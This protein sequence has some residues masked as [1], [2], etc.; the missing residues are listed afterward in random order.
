[1]L[2]N[3]Y[4]FIFVF[5]PLSLAGWYFFNRI[6]CYRLAQGYLIGM[7]LW[8]YAYFDVRYLL[9]LAVS[10]IGGY[11]LCVLCRRLRD[12]GAARSCG[13]LL[14][15]AGC[16]FHLGML[17][18]FKYTGF[19]LE[20]IFSLTGRAFTPLHILLPVGISFYTFQQLAYFLDCVRGETS[21]C[22]F[23]DYVS[24]IVYFPQI[25]QGP[26]LLHGE[27]IGQ[28][29]EEERRRFDAERFAK[30]MA[31]FV[32]GLSKKALLADTLGKAVN[33]GYDNVALLDSPSALFL[34]AGYMIELYFDFSGYCDMAVGLGKMFGIEIAENFD[35]P[36]KS[37]SVKE[38][39][40]RW[41]ITLGRFFT[42]YVY[43]PL[44]GSRKGKLR[45][46]CNTMIVFLF[47][48]FWHGAGWNFVFWGFLHGIGVAASALGGKKI[49][50]ACAAGSECRVSAPALGRKKTDAGASGAAA[51][52]SDRSGGLRGLRRPLQQI[53][54]FAYVTLTFVFF[55]ASTLAQGFAVIGKIFRFRWNGFLFR[56]AEALD[57]TELYAVTK[58]LDMG[59]PAL[60]PWVNLLVFLLFFLLCAFLLVGKKASAFVEEKPFSFSRT[61]LLSV[62]FVWSVLSLS[63]VSTFLYFTF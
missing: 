50:T 53:F 10:C 39:W 58:A 37:A 40:R 15:A 20:N 24:F 56:M 61:V 43:I 47:S 2:F 31:R 44:G 57:V 35:A 6:K 60:L 45:T 22:S 25:L 63:G 48:G 27:L 14:T 9:S 33:F 26:I 55:R 46:V 38:F 62:L 36:F 4:I 54:T 12:K 11:F 29:H 30:G 52:G 19:F 18:Y 51:E 16:L 17:G 42:R 1:M 21:V 5:L 7:S 28:F 59:A 32:L 23:L 49:F 8:F 3:S 34:A 41:H 13:K